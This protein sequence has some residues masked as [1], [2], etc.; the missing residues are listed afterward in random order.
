MLYSAR[1]VRSGYSSTCPFQGWFRI[2]RKRTLED[3]VLLLSCAGEE[4]APD[5]GIRSFVVDRNID[6]V[7]ADGSKNTLYIGT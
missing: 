6:L 5:H 7:D 3:R 2:D 4:L 1:V